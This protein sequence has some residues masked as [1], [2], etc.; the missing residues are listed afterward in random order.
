MEDKT[1]DNTSPDTP[2]NENDIVI[3]PLDFDKVEHKWGV[4]KQFGKPG[5]PQ[6][7]PEAKKAGWAKRKRNQELARTLLGMKFVGQDNSRIGKLFRD[8]LST[9]F[10]LTAQQI[11]EL[12]NEAAMMLRLIGSAV[13]DGDNDAAREIMDRAYGKPTQFIDMSTEDEQRPM[14]NIQVINSL[15][16]GTQMPEIKT[17]ENEI[18]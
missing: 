8:K 17:D 7:S 5:Q 10:G 3:T 6:P 13:E 1:P 16:S 4:T 9:Y 14:I 12:D 2:K 15:P 11:E 18:I